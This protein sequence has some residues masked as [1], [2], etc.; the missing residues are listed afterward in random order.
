MDD[1]AGV[2]EQRFYPAPQAESVESEH[3]GGFYRVLLR[4]GSIRAERQ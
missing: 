1:E 3:G 4:I 2:G